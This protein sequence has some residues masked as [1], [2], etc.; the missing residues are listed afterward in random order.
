MFSSADQDAPQDE[1]TLS[2]TDTLLQSIQTASRCGSPIRLHVVTMGG[3]SVNGSEARIDLA[4]SALWGMGRVSQVEHPE[5][6]C[7]LIDL[8]PDALIADQASQLAAAMFAGQEDQVAIRG[9]ETFVCRLRGDSDALPADTAASVRGPLPLPASG[10]FRLRLDGSN[11]IDGLW[12]EQA[13]RSQ[14]DA[15][16]VEL[17][18]KAAGLNFSDVLKAMGLY[19]G[20][21]DAIVPIGIEC[22]GIV[23][24][25]GEGVDRFQPG[26]RVFGVAP[27]SFSSH[28]IT[29][30][31]A[32]APVPKGMDDESASTIPITFLTAHYA[33]V[34]LADLQP[35]ER[36][37]IHA[38]AGG[39]G[40]A[41]IQIAQRIGAEIYA[42]AG[43]DEKRDFLRGLGVENIYNSRTLDFAD[44]I[45]RD[46]GREGVDVVL[47]S[48]PGEAIDRSIG[49]L[50]AYGRF[51]EIGKTDIYSNRMIGLL[52]F[53]DNLSYHAIDLDRMLRQRGATI[54]RLYDEVLPSFTAGDYSPLQ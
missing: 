48:L 32:L 16:Q 7:R 44:E 38:G 53:Q 20:I 28:A 26:D 47:N 4:G 31:Y 22:S 13:R 1:R 40:L 30:D 23:T 50:R 37:L 17:E 3:Q 36:F 15:G 39:V 14:P 29:N 34:S 12:I 45:L 27:Y 25:V 19:P 5:L 2:A 33:M 6:S 42:T 11:S 52:P 9:E 51:L 41:A 10:P 21:T 46:T 54:Q 24:A 49:I 18:V 35:G 43:S 8:S